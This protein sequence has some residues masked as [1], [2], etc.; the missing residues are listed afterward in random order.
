MQGNCYRGDVKDVDA[1]RDEG[2][3]KVIEVEQFD[4]T[5]T[6][7]GCHDIIKDPALKDYRKSSKHNCAA[8]WGN[9]TPTQLSVY[10]YS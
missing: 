7:A 8:K 3:P 9:I 10:L 5:H 4:T 1:Y 6:D 2:L